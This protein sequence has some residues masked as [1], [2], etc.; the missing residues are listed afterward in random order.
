MSN[1]TNELRLWAQ[2]DIV[3]GDV[4]EYLMAAASTIEELETEKAHVREGLAKIL[5]DVQ[6]HQRWEGDPL[7][8][9]TE[10]GSWRDMEPDLLALL[11]PEEEN[12]G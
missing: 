12:H 1:F 7:D 11:T 5:K 10:R 9:R 6:A 2:D 8:Y 3:P 4:A